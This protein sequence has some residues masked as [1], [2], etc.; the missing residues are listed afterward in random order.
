MSITNK[1][2]NTIPHDYSDI[3]QLYSRQRPLSF[4]TAENNEEKQSENNIKHVIAL[5]G[6]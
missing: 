2:Q 1:N 6:Q 4:S 5:P 3:C